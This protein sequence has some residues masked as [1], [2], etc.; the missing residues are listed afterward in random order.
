LYCFFFKFKYTL[1]LNQ[2]QTALYSNKVSKKILTLF[3]LYKASDFK[4]KSMI[5]TTLYVRS[6]NKTAFMVAHLML[7]IFEKYFS[8]KSY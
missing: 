2:L 5:K 8:S 7:L 1:Q 6:K 3:L 4:T